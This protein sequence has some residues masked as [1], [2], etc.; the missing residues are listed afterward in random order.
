ML[1]FL[2]SA[3][4]SNNPTYI[5]SAFES[6]IRT[7]LALP[8][9]PAVILLEGLGLHRPEPVAEEMHRAV[10]NAYDIPVISARDALWHHIWHHKKEQLQLRHGPHQSGAWHHKFACMVFGN[11]IREVHSKF[12]MSDWYEVYD[13]KPVFGGITLQCDKPSCLVGDELQQAPTY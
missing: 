10:A 12:T 4:T 8:K 2:A 3:N 11:W 1:P 9:H 5:R 13:Q 6:L 7:A